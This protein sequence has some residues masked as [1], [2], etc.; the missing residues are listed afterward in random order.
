MCHCL[1]CQRRTGSVYGVQARFPRAKVTLEGRS[2]TFRREAASG[3]TL[4]FRFCPECGATVFWTIDSQPDLVAVAVGAFA[5]PAFPA[6]K[7]SVF[8]STRHAWAMGSNDLEVEH[9][10]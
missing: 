5:D 3:N 10:G 6:P 7:Y 2:T 8:E 1:A 9:P 4:A